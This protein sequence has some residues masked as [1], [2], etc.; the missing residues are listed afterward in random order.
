MEGKISAISGDI[1]EDYKGYNG[2]C[3]SSTP[4]CSCNN[5]KHPSLPTSDP[6]A[7]QRKMT[8]KRNR[9][10]HPNVDSALKKR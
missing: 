10:P 4:A 9:Q 3:P 7:S 2:K 5:G 6:H 8:V 1:T